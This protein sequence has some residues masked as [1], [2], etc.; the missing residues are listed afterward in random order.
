VGRILLGVS[1]PRS[2]A[3][4][5]DD[6]GGVAEGNGRNVVERAFGIIIMWEFFRIV[7]ADYVRAWSHL[8]R[9]LRYGRNDKVGRGIMPRRCMQRRGEMTKSGGRE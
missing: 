9:F 1:R 7:W 8:E 6:K 2:F 4:L 5:E 3:L